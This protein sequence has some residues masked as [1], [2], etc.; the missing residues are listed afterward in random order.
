MT[1]APATEEATPQHDREPR[2]YDVAILG[3]GVI[4]S[5]WAALLLPTGNRVT[6]IT[7]RA[8]GDD[9]LRAAIRQ[10]IAASPRTGSCDN[11]GRLTITQSQDAIAGAAVVIEAVSEDLQ[12]KQQLFADVADRAR[13]DA[14]LL[15]S[16]STLLPEDLGAALPSPSRVVVAHPFNPVHTIPLVEVV[17]GETATDDITSRARDFLTDV[18]LVPVAL[19]KPIAGFVANRL[20]TALLR[21]SIHLIQ[22][23]VATARDIDEAITESIGLRWAAIGPFLAL[24]LAG[25]TNG[26][27][28]WFDHIGRGLGAGW[29]QLGNP[30][31]DEQTIETVIR[32]TETGYPQDLGELTAYRDERQL[33][34]L[35]ARGTATQ[36]HPEEK[37]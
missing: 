10:Q 18:G 20:Q 25:G 8:D 5:G 36:H 35:A 2:R 27:R 3:G 26:V 28:G 12:L 16:T 6:V 14:L 9:R 4:G 24:H 21:E 34:I 30:E 33:R 31:L 32:Q 15:S 23:G 1:T 13:A 11:M 37:P 29:T 19:G 17:T 22:E 7:L